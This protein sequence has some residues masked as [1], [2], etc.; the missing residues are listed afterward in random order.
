MAAA[1]TWAEARP[2]EQLHASDLATSGVVFHHRDFLY[3]T[4]GENLANGGMGSVFVLQR[5]PKHGDDRIENVVGKTFHSKYLYQLRTDEVTRREHTA[6]LSAIQEIAALQH[7]NLLPTYVSA[8]I[9]DN[10]LFISPRKADTLKEAVAKGILAPHERVA[11]LMQALEGM[12]VLHEARVLHRDFTLRNILLE[13]GSERAYLFD[14]DLALRLDDVAGATYKSHYKGRIFGSPGFS[15]PPETLDPALMECAITQRL[16]LFAIGGALFSLFTDQTPY[17]PNEDMWGLLVN[18][19][20]GVVIG[21]K[22]RVVYTDTVP[23]PL[24]PVIESC[25]ERD[26][27]N[28]VG[29]VRTVLEK[30]RKCLP[31][32]EAAMPAAETFHHTITIPPSSDT[33]TERL[34]VVHK[35]RLDQ[36]VTKEVIEN[37]DQALARYG[38][39]VQRSLGRAKNHPIFL[40]A[41]N[42]ALVAQGKFHDDNTFPKV[43]TAQDLAGRD[44]T[45]RVLDLWFGSYLPILHRVRQGLLTTL[46]RAVYDERTNHLLLF[47]EYVKDARFGPDLADHDLTMEEA[48]GLAYLVAKQVSRLHEQGLAHNNVRAESLLLKG[49]R[50]SGDVHPAM[51]GLVE[52]SID[53]RAM[54]DDVRQLAALT[55]T[56]L[57]PSRVEAADARVRACV[58]DLQARLARTAYEEQDTPLVVHDIVC[59][60]ADGL[61]AID[62][63]FGVLRENMGDLEAYSLLLISKPLY[64]RLWMS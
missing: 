63:N 38:Y 5:R 60:I 39:Q 2:L 9:A 4:T 59:M 16:D 15:V 45:Q 20:D 56:W 6:T 37:V 32:L 58:E 44:D 64:G 35:S 7:P 3:R 25:L 27:G 26:P 34:E 21:G 61:S 48:L 50:E 19:A 13:S 57:R 1:K 33:K 43:V 47:S 42:P 30:L 10:H 14:F 46:Y 55:L 12:Q 11:L 54:I 29:S 49:L 36:S 62:F 28:R 18:I 8:P 53:P 17:G 24:R 41:P 52:P 23:K 22:S 40:A 31:E 51:L